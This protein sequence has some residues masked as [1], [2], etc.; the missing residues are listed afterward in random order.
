MR[1]YNDPYPYF[2]GM[3][4][5]I[6]LPYFELAYDQP[7]RT[8]GITKNNFYTLYDVAMLGITSHSKVPLRFVTLLGFASSL[9]SLLVGARISGLQTHL[10]VP[11]RRGYRSAGAGAF[12]PGILCNCC[13]CGILG[14]Y[15]GSIYTQVQKRPYVI[16]KERLNFDYEP[17]AA[18]DHG[19]VRGWRA[20]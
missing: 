6:G 4:A 8:R 12:L 10:L 1:A 18:A 7:S 15:V 9:L 13:R 14:E 3:I 19:S 16:E 17:V 5:E 20:R 11:V 2:R